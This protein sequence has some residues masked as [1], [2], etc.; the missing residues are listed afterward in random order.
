MINALSIDTE[1]YFQAKAME[2]VIHFQEWGQQESRIR[3]NVYRILNL[4][5][6]VRTRATFF[7]LA[8]N[9]ERYPELVKDIQ[10]EGHE[11]AC[12]GYKHMD[13]YRQTQEEFRADV[14]RSRRILEQIAHVAI[15]GYRAPT[16][17][18]RQDTLWALDILLE[19]GF[20][21]DSSIFPIFHDRYG[22]PDSPRFPYRV[23]TPKNKSIREFPLSTISIL[24]QNFPIA[25]GG[26]FRLLPYP[27]IRRAVLQLN[28]KERR[29]A[30]IYLHPWELD[31]DQPRLPIGPINQF[32]HYINLHKTEKKLTR[33]LQD[34]RFAPLGEILAREE[35]KVSLPL[36][37]LCEGPKDLLENLNNF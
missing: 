2:S 7:I 37:Q 1:D 19:E 26:Y 30:V 24:G 8:W 33:L 5:Q 11:I 27:V 28:R 6:K 29:P 35:K 15:K 12:H 23:R 14:G 21:Y 31:P 25:G 36:I 17:S 32:R 3:S 13:I 20:R 9:A 34:F 22:I 10:S 16:F 18:I 4:F